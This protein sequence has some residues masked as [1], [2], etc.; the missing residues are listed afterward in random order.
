MLVRVTW[1]ISGVRR[2]LARDTGR[3]ECSGALC[4]VVGGFP[5]KRTN[6]EI[7]TRSPD[8][9]SGFRRIP[10]SLGVGSGRQAPRFFGHQDAFDPGGIDA[11]VDEV[12]VAEDPPVERDR[13]LD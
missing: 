9:S 4:M 2:G 5:C 11:P 8:R 6:I 1:R 10:N 3:K 13:G 7:T 12:S